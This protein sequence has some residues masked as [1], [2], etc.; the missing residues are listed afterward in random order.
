MRRFLPA[1]SLWPR[2]LFSEVVGLERIDNVRDV[3]VERALDLPD[4]FRVGLLV[5]ERPLHPLV[6]GRVRS[7]GIRVRMPHTQPL[8]FS[9]LA[10]LFALTQFILKLL[11]LLSCLL[12]RRLLR[13]KE[14][15]HLAGFVGK[16]LRYLFPGIVRIQVLKSWILCGRPVSE[17]LLELVVLLPQVLVLALDGGQPALKRRISL[18]QVARV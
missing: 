10:L 17:L 4:Q 9:A 6:E 15:S 12:E 8:P 1:R 2:G 3:L 5:V 11:D 13:G 7:H 16:L 18:K 14:L